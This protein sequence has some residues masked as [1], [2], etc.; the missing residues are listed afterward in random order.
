VSTCRAKRIR[1]SPGH[2]LRLIFVDPVA[3]LFRP[4]TGERLCRA[5]RCLRALPAT[6]ALLALL[7]LAANSF[8]VADQT[9]SSQ[10][11]TEHSGK[12]AVKATYEAYLRAWKDKGYTALNNLLSD[13]YQAVNFQG[14]VSTKANEIATAKG[15]RAYNTLSG[16]VLSVALVGDCAIAS[17]LIEAGWKDEHENPQTST[18]RFLAVLQKQKSDWK[19]VATQ[20]T[21]FNKPAEP[22]KK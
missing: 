15:D 20:S 3:V 16:N 5:Q 13:N 1:R 8:C 19:L 7:F 9:G 6:E 21:K 2:R 10:F 17:G 14:I 22:G 4:R 12:G 11:L 18:F